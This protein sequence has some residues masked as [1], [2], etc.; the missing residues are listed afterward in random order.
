MRSESLVL[1]VLIFAICIGGCA[2]ERTQLEDSAAD[3]LASLDDE[4]DF[5]DSVAN[6]RILT[7]SDALHGLLLLASEDDPAAD[8]QGRLAAA[9]G[10]GWVPEKSDLPAN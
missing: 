1:S 4:L 3:T 6:R 8:F 7:N 9:K 2:M 5:W 10:L